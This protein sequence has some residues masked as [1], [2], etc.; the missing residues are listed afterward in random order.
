MRVLGLAT[1][2]AMRDGIS[3]GFHFRG[4]QRPRCAAHGPA[5][6]VVHGAIF[7][8]V[9]DEDM[10]RRLA[11]HMTDSFWQSA[12][13]VRLEPQLRCRPAGASWPRVFVLRTSDIR[14]DTD[15]APYIIP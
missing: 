15:G 7:D 12:T 14:Y 9:G 13:F 2:P 10:E 11:A 6:S 4:L 5:G 8:G 1:A 3:I